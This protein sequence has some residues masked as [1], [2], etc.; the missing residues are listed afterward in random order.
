MNILVGQ[1]GHEA[2]NFCTKDVTYEEF[3]SLNYFTGEDSLWRYKNVEHLFGGIIKAAEEHGDI[4]LIP[5]MDLMNPIGRMEKEALDKI[6]DN[7]ISMIEPHKNDLDGVL[8]CLHGAGRA[9][10]VE[11]I[12]SYTLEKIK[13][14]LP[15]NI[16][17]MSALDL[18]ANVSKEMVELSDGLFGG[19]E[20]P[21]IDFFNTGYLAMKTLISSIENRVIPK[22]S[23]KAIPLLL[24]LSGGFTLREPITTLNNY[25]KNYIKENNLIDAT[26]FHGFPYADTSYASSTI[27]VMTNND[28]ELADKSAQELAEHVWEYRE[29][30]IPEIISAKK[31]MDQAE[32]YSGDGYVLISEVSDNPGGG[33]PG[34]GTHLLKEML[35]RNLPKTIF[36]FIYD[37]DVA[38]FLHNHRVGDKVTFSLGGKCEKIHGNP[39]EIV[40]AKI[41]NLSNGEYIATAPMIKGAKLS[42]GKSAR[43]KVKNVEIIITSQRTQTLDDRPFLVTGADVAQYKYVGIKSSNHYR[44]FFQDKA[45][46]IIPCDTP[47]VM[48]GDLSVLDFKYVKMPKYPLDLNTKL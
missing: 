12:E 21:H 34:D 28:Q 48:T 25:I 20:Y 4:N 47:G 41:K 5:T 38:E 2:N 8:F 31:A 10:G 33:A 30:F 40:N 13:A 22:M 7:I 39:I 43:V 19:Y 14:I 11:D 1:F 9:V 26:F 6:V 15:D 32:E 18:H 42:F 16:P 3:I 37:K 27:L 17:I 29:Y 36:G 24:P 46:L 35:D 23:L 45:G 44:S